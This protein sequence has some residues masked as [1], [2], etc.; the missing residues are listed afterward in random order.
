M[1]KILVVLLSLIFTFSLFGCEKIPRPSSEPEKESVSESVYEEPTDPIIACGTVNLADEIAVFSQIF[2]NDFVNITANLQAPIGGEYHDLVVTLN[3]RRTYSGYDVIIVG[4]LAGWRDTEVVVPY[5]RV[6]YVDGYYAYGIAEGPS[7]GDMAFESGKGL[8]FNQFVSLLNEKIYQDDALRLTYQALKPELAN[9]FKGFKYSQGEQ[10][11]SNLYAELLDKVEEYQNRPVYEFIVEGLMGLGLTDGEKLQTLENQIIEICSGNPSVA[12]FIDRVVALVNGYLPPYAQIDLKATVDGLQTALGVTTAD[13][14]A[15]LKAEN[16]DLESMLRNPKEGETLYDY[17]RSFLRLISVDM[18]AQQFGGG[19]DST[20]DVLVKSL[21]DG[22]KQ[23][24]LKDFLENLPTDIDA[25]VETIDE[26]YRQTVKDIVTQIKNYLDG[27]SSVIPRGD[28]CARYVF[29]VD[30]SGRPASF[31]CRID[32]SI[33][34]NEMVEGLENGFT[35][36]AGLSVRF[37]Y[38]DQG[39]DF[40]MPYEIELC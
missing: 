32:A 35:Y 27:K 40:T 29:D 5:F 14:V 9:N 15:K 19:Q 20:F 21:I 1:K 36:Y 17:I 26:E 7:V 3:A 34:P 11:F 18:L 6:W 25:W 31:E 24:T 10:S 2:D 23:V 39:V 13:I 28:A 38:E 8:T 12:S 16:P 4:D 37:N 22:S 30:E 33:Y